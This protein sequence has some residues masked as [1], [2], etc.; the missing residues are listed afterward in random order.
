MKKFSDDIESEHMLIEKAFAGFIKNNIFSNDINTEEFAGF[1]EIYSMVN[2][3]SHFA[4]CEKFEKLPDDQKFT[5]SGL[6]LLIF[7]IKNLRETGI[8]SAAGITGDYISKII[9]YYEKTDEYLLNEHKKES[10]ICQI[11]DHDKHLLDHIVSEA[12]FYTIMYL[13]E[14]SISVHLDR[15]GSDLRVSIIEKTLKRFDSRTDADLLNK[16][17][18]MA[19]GIERYEGRF[20]AYSALIQ[21]AYLND[22]SEKVKKYYQKI[23]ELVIPEDI[24]SGFYHANLMKELFRIIY[25]M[26]DIEF[27]RRDL[28]RLAGI[29]QCEKLVIEPLEYSLMLEYNKTQKNISLDQIE[30]L[31]TLSENSGNLKKLSLR[32]LQKFFEFT[33]PDINLSGRIDLVSRIINLIMFL[34]DQVDVFKELVK[35]GAVLFRSGD[36]Y[37]AGKVFEISGR[38]LSDIFKDAL[39]KKAGLEIFGKTRNTDQSYSVLLKDTVTYNQ[40]IL[41]EQAVISLAVYLYKTGSETE[42]LKVIERFDNGSE[43]VYAMCAVIESAFQTDNKNEGNELLEEA[44]K[45]CRNIADKDDRMKATGHLAVLYVK[46]R[47]HDRARELYKTVSSENNGR[48]I[49]TESFKEYAI[50]LVYAGLFSEAMSVFSQLKKN[51]GFDFFSNDCMI[52]PATTRDANIIKLVSYLNRRQKF[53]ERDELLRLII[54]KAENTSTRESKNVDMNKSRAT[55]SELTDELTQADLRLLLGKADNTSTRESVNIYINI[56]KSLGSELTDQFKVEMIDRFLTDCENSSDENLWRI[57]S[58]IVIREL[59]TNKNLNERLT[60]LKRALKID[61]NWYESIIVEDAECRQILIDVF[62]EFAENDSEKIKEE[63]YHQTAESS[64]IFFNDRTPLQSSIE[65]YQK[66]FIKY[67]NRKQNE[68]DSD[69]ILSDYFEPIIVIPDNPYEFESCFIELFT[70]LDSAISSEIFLKLSAGC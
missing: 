60:Y 25:D 41:L 67:I 9:D 33:G 48:Y 51:D 7:L 16:C 39:K 65:N 53:K 21:I 6:N 58:D 18:Y 10:I 20:E 24:S 62:K 44:E 70:S 12:L 15:I 43:K 40:K 37:S 30:M 61:L 68:I 66:D 57:N 23:S 36:E 13:K 52:P 42:A 55:D 31:V 59:V 4:A 27:I 63:K 45:L 46:L 29:Y 22:N 69:T 17:D 54:D 38:Y 8:E 34:E 49:R 32:D 28:P 35:F 50:A 14:E 1:K 3:N 19:Q 47:Q 26:S 11:F 2:E 5:F 56:L 64:A